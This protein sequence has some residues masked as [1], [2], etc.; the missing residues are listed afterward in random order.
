MKTFL[1][2]ILFN[3]LFLAGPMGS[4]SFAVDIKD[5]FFEAASEHFRARYTLESERETVNGILRR[6]EDY[7]VRV[8]NDIG[9]SR[10]EDFWTWDRRVVIVLYPD[11]Y[12]FERFTGSPAWSKGYASRDTRIYRE[13][14]IVSY[15]GQENF[16][17]EVLPHEIAH[18]M[19]WDYLHTPRAVPVWFEEGVAQLQET[20]QKDKVQ[21]A[22]RPLIVQGK[23]IP[24][25]SLELMTITGEKDNIKVSLF[26]AQSLSIVVFLIQKYGMDPF[27]RLCRELR[28]GM[29]FELALAHAYPSL[30]DSVDALE[31]RWV[32]YFSEQ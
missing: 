23:Y 18:L 3:I 11:Q 8:A 24:L 19:L 20:E 27:H 30:I 6:A 26:Y 12:A 21:D 29:S 1:F 14:T 31:K 5:P 7:Y 2:F 16:L 22:L 9:Y 13:R 15:G 4:V 10:Y 17:D 28:D 25:A 32:K